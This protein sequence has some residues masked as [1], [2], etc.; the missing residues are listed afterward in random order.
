MN[1]KKKIIILISSIVLLLIIAAIVVYTKAVADPPEDDLNT[2][3]LRADKLMGTQYTE[4]LP[5]WGNAITKDLIAGVYNTLTLND[6]NHTGNTSPD[7]MV[8]KVDLDKI[9]KDC[10]A[11][12]IILN[13]PRIW[14]VDWIEVNAGKIRNFDGLDAYWVMWFYIPKNFKGE[15]AP[16]ERMEGNRDTHMGIKAGSSACILDDPEGTSWVMKS[17]GRVQHPEQKFSSLI[18]LGSKLKLPDGWAWRYVILDRELIFQ[19]DQGK[20]WITQDDM[21]NTYDRVGGNFSNYKP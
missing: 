21:G 16:Y 7:E 12:K 17:M 2:K 9:K 15:I 10:G 3:P 20:V 19:P 11:L 6:P 13:G 14:T 4:I 8:A 1:R 18:N 5:V